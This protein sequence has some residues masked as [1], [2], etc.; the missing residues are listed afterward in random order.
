MRLSTRIGYLPSAALLGFLS[1][2]QSAEADV[3]CRS[4]DAEELCLV[5]WTWCDDRVIQSYKD[6]RK[7]C[8]ARCVVAVH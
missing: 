2:T 8:T 6:C 1:L 5:E 7:A 3:E 4:A